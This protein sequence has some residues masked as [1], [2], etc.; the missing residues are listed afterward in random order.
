MEFLT[1]MRDD[2]MED[3]QERR[4]HL[5]F[6]SPEDAIALLSLDQKDF[7]KIEEGGNFQFEQY[8]SA[9]I[10]DQ[11]Y[12]GCCLVLVRDGHKCKFTQ[13][14]HL[15][16]KVGRLN[17]MQ[18]EVKWIDIIDE[19]LVKIGIEYLDTKVY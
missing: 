9:L 1:R 19:R 15:A 3:A 11:S 13:K 8:F 2:H 4:S 12:S 14:M 17:P 16:V 10:Y 5:R 7:A 18:A 6:T